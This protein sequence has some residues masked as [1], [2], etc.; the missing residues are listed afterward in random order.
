MDPIS[1][2]D[3]N[4]PIIHDHETVRMIGRGAYGEVWLAKSV[5]GTWRAVKVVWR[6]DYDYE[7]AFEREFEAIKKFEPVSRKH[8]GLVP[9]LQVGR[10]TEAGFYYYVMELA[11]DAELGKDFKPE[12]YRPSTML[13]KM[14]KAKRLSAEETL[15]DGASIAEGLHFM[16]QNG[17]IHRDVKPSNLV[18]VD[19]V[20]RLADLGLVALLGQ[21]SFVGTEGFVAPEG[22]G[23]PQSD[24]FSLGMVL[25]EASTGKDRLTFPDLPSSEEK[26]EEGLKL[27][28]RLQNVI[29]RACAHRKQDRFESAAQMAA[30]L[31]GEV[32]PHQLGKK[33]LM[34]R[35]LM[36]TGAV[37]FAALVILAM[38]QSEKLGFHSKSVLT[39]TSQP[40]GAEV[41]S[42]GVRLGV[43]PLEVLPEDGVA[44]IYQFRLKGFRVQEIEHVASSKQ[45]SKLHANLGVSQLPQ[46]GERWQNGLKM[47]FMPKQSGHLSE[48]PV[49]MKY[50]DAFLKSTGRTFEG[51]IL[52]Y[53]KPGEKK[54]IHIVVVPPLDAETF[55]SWLTDQD[56]DKGFLTNEHHYELEMQSITESKTPHRPQENVPE[57]E[58]V[59]APSDWQAFQVRVARQTY[60]GLE[61]KTD[62]PN[63]DVY[64]H[65]EL[66]G[67]T[68]LE[69]PRIKTGAV[70]LELRGDGFTDLLVEGDIVEHE[71]L[72]IYAD[73]ETRRQVVFG[74]EWRN[75]IG[76]KFLPLGDVLMAATETRRRDYMEFAKNEN[77]RRPMQLSNQAKPS[78]LPVIGVSWEEAKQFCDWL[79]KKEQALDLIGSTDYYRLPTDEEWSKAAG[80]PAERGK[81]PS[82]KN[83]RIRGIYPWG[84]VWPPAR[85]RENLADV[86]FAQ[87]HG[88]DP[89]LKNYEDRSPFLAPVNK[90]GAKGF[91]HLGGNVSEWVETPFK[92]D[93][94]LLSEKEANATVRGGNWRTSKQDDLL[95]ST[96]I[97][98]NY[99]AR[100]DTVGF[101]VVLA[102]KGS[103][104]SVEPVVVPEV[105]VSE[106]SSK[107]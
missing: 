37:G 23:T 21:R 87:F 48:T 69:I 16:H 28:R 96:R 102:K 101:R 14:K 25:Y 100:R 70:E 38:N 62:P 40:E 12:S 54:P 2:Q 27:W 97:S 90:L 20:C 79:T 98:L 41:Y 17:L 4:K 65:D 99:K 32:S 76:L 22:P 8:P 80:L 50:F 75:S 64:L 92:S 61:V 42:S 73:L 24:I 10:N 81:D 107:P 82:E 5:T 45:A 78:A 53:L 83:G 19:G 67:T 103:P 72:E 30:A 59:E 39:L 84:F 71:I 46:T 56:R 33:K 6:S 68:P 1:S 60:G 31:R 47:R 94:P 55:R 43:T 58:E 93:Q 86:A 11:D 3:R 77:A 13:A 63:I 29:C 88:S 35:V 66:L 9:V 95:A 85:G 89:H 15:K 26:S 104:L 36:A 49:E 106:T 51:K 34:Q 57:S 44:Q 105:K 7:E 52:S 18:Y 91:Q 74:R